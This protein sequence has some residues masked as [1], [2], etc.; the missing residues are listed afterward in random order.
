MSRSRI[1]WLGHSTVRIETS[2]GK[3]L[4][5]DPWLK[6]NPSCP[7]PQKKLAKLDAMLIT[8]GHYDHIADAVDLGRALRPEVVC[9][10]ETALWLESKSVP[11]LRGMNKGGSQ[12]VCGVKVTM[13]HAEHSCGIQDGDTLVYGGE[14]AGYVLELPDGLRIYHAGDTALFGDM[15]LI[16]EL[17]GPDLAMLPIGDLYTMGPLEAARAVELLGVRRVLPIHWG[18]FPPLTGTPEALRERLAG[19]GVEVHALRAGESL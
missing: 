13:V 19:R 11:N 9:I 6:Q 1:T 4:L 3:S 12:E 17:Y 7:A 8:H 15:R 16:G 2:T 5:I 10:H 18:T 14:A